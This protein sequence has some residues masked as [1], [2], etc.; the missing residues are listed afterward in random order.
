MSF[1]VLSHNTQNLINLLSVNRGFVGSLWFAIFLQLFLILGVLYTLATDS[2]AMHRFQISVFGAIAIVFAVDGVNQGLFTDAASLNAMGVGWLLL[3]IVDILWVLYF[4][5]EEDS[6]AL[7]IFNSLGNG[8]LSSPSRRRR[9]R[10]QSAMHDMPSGNGYPTNYALGGG[11]SSHDGY[12]S[13]IGTGAYGSPNTGAIRSQNSF[14]GSLNDNVPKTGTVGTGGTG[15]LRNEMAT[16]SIANGVDNGPNSPLMAGVGA[17]NATSNPDPQRQQPSPQPDN[18]QYR[19]K[20]LYACELFFFFSPHL[21][22]TPILQCLIC[23][24]DT[25]NSEDPTEISFAKGEILDI[26]DKQ[27][28]WWQSRRADGSTGSEFIYSFYPTFS[29]F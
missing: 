10:T 25:A 5:S 17:G 3:A 22:L 8:G 29:F 20:A 7:H 1:V 14:G 26:V 19:A 13:K 6:L 12:D 21:S 4:T 18:Y 23:S 28:K 16:G 11:I 15:S 24:V 2:I 9:T 27:G